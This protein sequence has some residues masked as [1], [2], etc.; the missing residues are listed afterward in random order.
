V[1]EGREPLKRFHRKNRESLA[2]VATANVDARSTREGVLME[3][4]LLAPA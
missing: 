4:I 2:E 1:R 3:R